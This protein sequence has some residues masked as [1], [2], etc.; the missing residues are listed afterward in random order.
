MVSAP[1]IVL[2]RDAADWRVRSAYWSSRNRSAR[3]GGVLRADR[4][5]TFT[6]ASEP[7]GF[8]RM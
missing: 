5:Q 7:E 2:T 1:Q 4:A 8:H 6:G 3:R